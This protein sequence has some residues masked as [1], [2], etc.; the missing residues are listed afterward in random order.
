[1]RLFCG[2]SLATAFWTIW[3]CRTGTGRT[4][5]NLLVS[6]ARK[7]FLKLASY[8]WIG[9][10][11]NLIN[12][13][14]LDYDYNEFNSNWLELDF[15]ALRWHLLWF[16]A[17]WIKWTGFNLTGRSNN[18]A[19]SYKGMNLWWQWWFYFCDDFKLVKAVL[20][21]RGELLIKAELRIKYNTQIF[22]TGFEIWSEIIQVGY[23]GV[24][25][26]GGAKYNHL[27]H[28]NWVGGNYSPFWLWL[29]Q[30]TLGESERT[31]SIS[32]DIIIVSRL[33]LEYVNGNW[34]VLI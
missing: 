17:I 7:L 18:L 24:S 11:L 21:L 28:V 16:G 5:C 23:G 10:I 25:F 6:L 4:Q 12:W 3:R 9:Q 15:S 32:E 1:M 33:L 30:G 22:S 2:T 13:I 29:P 34:A 8:V 19:V 20:D 31:P 26:F 14:W 27:C